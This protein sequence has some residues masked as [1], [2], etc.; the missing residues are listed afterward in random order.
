MI[1]VYHFGY[2]EPTSPDISPFCIKLLT[3]LRMSGIPYE[4]MTGDVDKVPTQK[5]PVAKIDGQLIPDSS[6]IIAY[7]QQHDAR[8]L[9]D[10]HLD[11]RERASAAALQALMETK[12]YFCTLYLRWCTDEDFAKYRP[13]LVDYGR[14]RAPAWQRPLVPVIAPVLLQLA[15]RRA[16]HQAWAQGT[17]RWSVE[18]IEQTAI[19]GLAA[20]GDF[21]GDRPYLMG[22]QPSSI[23]A[24][25]FAWIHALTQHSM[26]ARVAAQVRKDARLMAYHDRMR[27]R[28]WRRDLVAP[29]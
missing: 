17:G 24:A 1:T 11:P 15:R 12:I 23:D 16:H 10:D 6:R 21:L 8:A 18:E 14:R 19:D 27:D 3:W 9:R 5:L 29:A 28:Y 25:G 22:D 20:I 2:P 4:S 7:L 26:C 13:L